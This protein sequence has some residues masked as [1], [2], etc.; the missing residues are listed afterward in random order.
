MTA[1]DYITRSLRT[2]GFIGEDQPLTAP[3]ANDA[4]LIFQDLVDAL[5]TDRRIVFSP[6]RQVFN[7]TASVGTYLAGP[8]AAFDTVRPQWIA[9]AK[10][11]RT[12]DPIPFEY[13]CDVLEESEWTNVALK[14]LPGSM[15][16]AIH[17]D[18]TFPNATIY[19]YPVPNVG[20]LQLV[21]YLPVLLVVPALLTTVIS[22]QPGYGRFFRTTLAIE[23]HPEF[24]RGRPLSPV[25]AKQATDAKKDV[26]DAR[27]ADQV[28]LLRPDPGIALGATGGG[29]YNIYSNQ[30][31]PR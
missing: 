31:R 14:T 23:L 5:N 27:V 1:L 26:L 17:M 4:L 16:T 18:D 20:T 29:R 7:L 19:A 2:I 15:V 11:M 30:N 8:G 12:T 6:A 22:I 13:R 25:L 9:A 10:V 21:L 28:G 24:G 3:Q